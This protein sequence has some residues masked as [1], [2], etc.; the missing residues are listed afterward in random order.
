MIFGI[1][2]EI[3]ERYKEYSKYEEAFLKIAK[4]V[5]TLSVNISVLES[6]Q[7]LNPVEISQYSP[8]KWY[9]HNETKKFFCVDY[10]Y[11]EFLTSDSFINGKIYPSMIFDAQVFKLFLVLSLNTY[12]YFVPVSKIDVNELLG[13]FDE[14]PDKSH[15]DLDL[16]V[17]YENIE[18]L[19]ELYKKW[20]I[21]SPEDIIRIL[22]ENL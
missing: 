6:S 11:D 15:G 4:E 7:K 14:I 9:I 8:E 17:N 10:S 1:I 22:N 5:G 2:D 20:R 18:K 12:D 19:E 21:N 13:V 3:L 16:E